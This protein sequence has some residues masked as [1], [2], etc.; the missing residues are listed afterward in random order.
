MKL[1]LLIFVILE[2]VICVTQTGAIDVIISRVE[3]YEDFSCKAVI[4]PL[5]TKTV[6]PVIGFGFSSK[7]TDFVN[8]DAA[9]ACY[10]RHTGAA[11]LI[12]GSETGTCSNITWSSGGWKNVEPWLLDIYKFNCTD[13]AVPT[14][15]IGD[16]NCTL[17][18]NHG[19]IPV[20]FTSVTDS[21]TVHDSMVTASQAAAITNSNAN[22]KNGQIE[23]PVGDL[24]CEDKSSS[25]V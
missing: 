22:W 15:S 21:Q 12:F 24:F 23:A 8:N 11:T 25:L 20:N 18:F 1:Q 6:R 16:Y 10:I 17:W 2:I 9:F 19:M 5:G 3:D 14:N 13:I 4:N 7:T